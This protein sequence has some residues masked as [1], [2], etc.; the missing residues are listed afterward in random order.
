MYTCIELRRITYENTSASII[1]V[2][3]K[4]ES[5]HPIKS[6]HDLRTRLSD[7]H[8]RCFA[9]FHPSLPNEPLVFVHVALLPQLPQSMQELQDHKKH[10]HQQQ[11]RILSFSSSHASH[12][13]EVL[14]DTHAAVF[15]S[16]NNIHKGLSGV[17]LG[18][19]LIKRVVEVLQKEFSSLNVFGTLSPLPNFRM[20]FKRNLLLQCQQQQQD[21]TADI[22]ISSV[23]DHDDNT[24]RATSLHG[25]NMMVTP[26]E[27]SSLSSVLG[28][29]TTKDTLESFIRTLETTR[30]YD[31]PILVEAF[32][33]ILMKHAAHYLVVEKHKKRPLDGVA[34]FHVRNGA[35]MYRLNF[36]AD[37]SRTVS[38]TYLAQNCMC[39]ASL[40]ATY[41][42]FMKGFLT[43]SCFLLI[44]QISTSIQKHKGM[45]NSFGI[46]VNYN[47][48]YETIER[49]HTLYE[50]KGTIPVMEGVARW[51][52]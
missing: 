19:F 27:V 12:D 21:T 48:N 5:V 43:F 2:I 30:W 31:Q 14:H 29:M 47:Y 33:P 1:E 11:M 3:A 45:H 49:N 38:V 35:E 7:P 46:M 20:W 25:H 13:E 17:D 22:A 52:K 9:L 41:K 42:I 6:L 18:S 10:Q 51:L 4:K 50:S 44:M 15:Y 16:I 36:L 32:R 40:E 34:K 37:K 28:K 8:R 26:E 24:H 39:I 23:A